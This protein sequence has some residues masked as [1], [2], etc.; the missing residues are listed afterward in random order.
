[1]IPGLYEVIQYTLFLSWT[2]PWFFRGLGSVLHAAT[3]L[4]AGVRKS[5]FVVD[6]GNGL[7]EGSVVQVNEGHIWDFVGARRQI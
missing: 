1:M 5:L 2:R 6:H 7:G 3:N 4:T